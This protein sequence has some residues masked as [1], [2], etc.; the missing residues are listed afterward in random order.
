MYGS[1]TT[2]QKWNII[3]IRVFKSVLWYYVHAPLCFLFYKCLM[4]SQE[5][6]NSGGHVEFNLDTHSPIQ[7]LGVEILKFGLEKEDLRELFSY[8]ALTST[9]PMSNNVNILNYVR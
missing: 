7:P 6:V 4:S 1:H 5:W 3:H 8:C 2:I 9:K